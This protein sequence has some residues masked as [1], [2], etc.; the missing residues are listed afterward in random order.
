M[1]RALF[2]F[3]SRAWVII[4]VSLLAAPAWA[5]TVKVPRDHPTIQG[6]VD[7]AAAGDE[8][9]VGKGC[10]CGATITKPL[11]L[12]G[13]KRGDTTIVGCAS[14]PVIGPG[15]RV[16]FL[17]P[18]TAG[19]GVASGT[20]I[21]GFS[22]DGKGVSSK[23]LGPLAFGVFSRFN[24]RIVVEDNEFQ[25][26]VQAITNTAGDNW[27]ISDNEIEKLTLFDCST[28]AGLC[29]GGVG[30]A[31][32]AASTAIGAPGGPADPA[33]RPEANA[34]VD[35]QVEGRAPRGFGVFAMDGILVFAA[36]GTALVDNRTRITA[37][38]ESSGDTLAIG[39][40]VTNS[41]CG[42][43]TPVLPGASYA[44]LVRNQ[45]DGEAGV[46]V[47]GTGGVNTKG[48]IL[49][50]NSCHVLVEGAPAPRLDAR[51][52]PLALQPQRTRFE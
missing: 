39:I 29:G 12:T 23:N 26:T 18:G 20:S 10:F 19:T 11:K 37:G 36:D 28:G 40:L 8:I 46:V 38:K 32:Q 52:A 13:G 2:H 1:S 25:G 15:L 3:V 5:R 51:L 16:G 24:H 34:V 4:A 6:A 47:E 33:N 27:S 7:A 42:E 14:S 17:L 35:N 30:I 48:L 22:F 41:C 31:I 50:K 21:R 44:S 49:F 45:D 9:E 43:P